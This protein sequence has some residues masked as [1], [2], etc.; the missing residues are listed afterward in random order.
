MIILTPDQA[1]LVR[2]VSPISPWA[3][4]DPVPL[5]DGTFILPEDVL[6]DPAHAD[7]ADFLGG[8]PTG[9]IDPS[10]FYGKDDGDQMAAL[11]LPTF[12]DVGERTLNSDAIEATLA[13]KAVKAS[14]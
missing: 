11:D 3:A 4:L 7:V 12:E 5:K 14:K 1:D 10:L 2:G 8:L 9:D 6:A 13:A